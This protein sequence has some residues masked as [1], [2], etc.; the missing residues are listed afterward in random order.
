MNT[1]VKVQGWDLNLSQKLVAF[2]EIAIDQ[3]VELLS[4]WSKAFP[5]E[6]TWVSTHL[7]IP[8]LICR[9]DCVV[10]EGK[11]EVFEVEERPAGIGITSNLNPDFKA[12][13]QNL[14][15]NWPRFSSVVSNDRK[16]SDDGLWLEK[17]SLEEA[18]NS[19]GLLLIRAEPEQIEFHE[20]QS[21]SVSSLIQ[22]G[23]KSYGDKLG[24]WTEVGIEDFD[25]LPWNQGFCIKPLQN[26]KCRDVEI[27][28]PW[29]N[30][31][32]T[33]IG[34]CSTRTRI[35]RILEKN[36]R[37]YLQNFISP[38]NSV[39]YGHMMILRV[40]FGYDALR[41]EYVFMGGVWNSRPNLKIHG[42]PDTVIG[43]IN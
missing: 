30:S 3:A 28:C 32:K 17:I 8:T 37:M 5:K 1:A 21:R 29:H 16:G 41:E 38:E 6:D 33:G 2:P 12:N 9:L 11:L 31:K 10:N 13:L 25:V 40:F 35:Y 7:G 42:T 39:V 26:S 19:D 22:K 4:D 27:W 14:Q 43:P 34:G 36:G 24:L 15:E 20:L 23:N 18:L